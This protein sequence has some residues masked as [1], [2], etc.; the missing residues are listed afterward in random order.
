MADSFDK[1]MAI[2]R[3]YADA[4]FELAEQADQVDTVHDELVELER[5]VASEPDFSAFLA[6]GAIDANDRRRSLEKMF[7]GKLCDAT[8]N[9]L[10][11]LNDHGRVDLIQP[12]L[13]AFTLAAEKARGQVE[14]VAISAVELSQTER[15]AITQLV[16]DK[17]GKQ[18]LV[19]FAVDPD[20]LGGLI[21]RIGDWQFDNSLRAQLTAAHERLRER[22]QRGL[23]VG[24]E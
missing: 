12:L 5:L 21:L 2:A 9:T 6:S 8:L 15:D 22:A 11:V 3:I 1:Q 10:L 18:P 24:T 7:R 20:I 14:A 13:R 23:P 16:A 17:S 19:D 4:L